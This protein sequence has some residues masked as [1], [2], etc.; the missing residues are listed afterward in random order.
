MQSW[1]NKNVTR[2]TTQGCNNVVVCRL[3]R[4]CWNNLATSLI[5]SKGCYKLLTTCSLLVTTTWDKQ[6][7]HNL[8]TACWQTCYKMWDF[9]VCTYVKISHL[10]Q[11]WCHQVC[12][13]LLTACTKLVDNLGQT[14]RTRLVDGV[15][16][17]S[18]ENS[19]GSGQ[20]FS[21]GPMTLIL[22]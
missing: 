6:C 13:K 7:E 18:R 14:V 8:L 12:Y 21:R 16:A 15:L 5:I 1:Y 9:Y 4:T 3:Y 10:V 2:L 19:L 11:V 17:G 22:S 20:I